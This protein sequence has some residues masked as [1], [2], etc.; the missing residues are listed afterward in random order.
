MCNELDIVV[1]F[2]HSSHNDS[3]QD[4]FLMRFQLC[5]MD[6]LAFDLRVIDSTCCTTF[7]C[8]SNWCELRDFERCELELPL[9]D[10]R[11]PRMET[12]AEGER[13]P[14][15]FWL[16]LN[17]AAHQFISLRYVTISRT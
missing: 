6:L 3:N 17:P 16:I 7:P 15:A 9:S 11:P 5:F 4:G 10:D 14:A 2:V 1:A 13:A 8:W 12:S